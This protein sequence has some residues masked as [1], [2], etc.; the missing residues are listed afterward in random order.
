[1]KICTNNPV[2]DIEKWSKKYFRSNEDLAANTIEVYERII[3]SF[4]EYIGV[5][6]NK[7][8]LSS[9]KEINEDFL[10]DFIEWLEE[11]SE[12]VSKFS[13]N[14]KILYLV[15]I[16]SLFSYIEKRA[17]HEKDGSIFTW[18]KEFEHVMKGKKK[19]KGNSELK[20]LDDNEITNLLDYLNYT[21][22]PEN[23]KYYNYIYS[24]AIR[25]ML[26]GGFRV[27]ELLNIRPKDIV[28]KDGIIEVK[29]MDTKSQMIQYVPIR[30]KHV[31]VELNYIASIKK[32]DA[33]IFTSLTGI[34]KIDRSNLYRKVNSIFKKAGIHDKK[35]LHTLR[36]TSAMLLLESSGDVSA[37]Q[38]LLRHTDISTTMI[39]V[40]RS[41]KKLAEKI[42]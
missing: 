9:I 26:F 14:T 6:K 18:D 32:E 7:K 42:I 19:R 28:R 5:Q 16:K 34:N 37:V 30:E 3:Y 41:T 25:M 29:L 22:E 39:Y 15:I 33:Y 24:F 12:T 27:S 36:H 38:Q 23:V 20:Y 21:L 4:T 35:G 31:Q 11:N 40:N 2:Y 17:E 8:T 1:M 10:L 13:P